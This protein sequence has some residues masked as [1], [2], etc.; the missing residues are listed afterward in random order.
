MNQCDECSRNMD[1]EGYIGDNIMLCHGCYSNDTL[2]KYNYLPQTTTER[3]TMKITEF[4][5]N[6]GGVGTTLSVVVTALQASEHQMKTVLIIDRSRNGDVSAMMALTSLQMN[7][8][9]WATGR[10]S[11]MRSRRLCMKIIN[12]YDLVLVDVGTTRDKKRRYKI[13]TAEGAP[14]RKADYSVLSIDN[15]YGALRNS[16]QDSAKY[17][18]VVIQHVPGRALTAMDCKH[19][20]SARLKPDA[21]KIVIESDLSTGRSMDAGLLCNRST[22]L[23]SR[24]LLQIANL[25]WGERF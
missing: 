6:K 10:V 25:G 13:L 19:V 24:N 9:V 20:V 5:S 8:E 16:V 2:R 15:S 4:K 11:I 3:N 18:A 21:D 1:L 14:V 12:A 7:E 22:D 23:F 17:D